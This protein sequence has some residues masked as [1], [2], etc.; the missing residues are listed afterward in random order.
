MKVN[1]IVKDRGT[2]ETIVGAK[3]F[4]SDAQGN[5]KNNLGSITDIDGKFSLE[6]P[7]GEISDGYLTA[8]FISYTPKTS[9]LTTNQSIYNFEIT[10]KVQSYDEVEIIAE[11][12]KT[13]CEK[14]GG[15]YDSVNRKCVLIANK[16]KIKAGEGIKKRLIIGGVILLL[17]TVGGLVI[18]KRFKK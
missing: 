10:D 11:S 12:P 9:K 14:Q 1:G 3:V 2:K 17:V 15:V 5:V 16:P 6:I 4:L 8:S 13:R 18:Y 7:S